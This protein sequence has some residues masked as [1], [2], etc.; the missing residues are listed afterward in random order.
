[1]SKH[2]PKD[3]DA[4]V[5]PTCSDVPEV[6]SASKID[7]AALLP[8][9]TGFFR[10]AGSLTTPPCSEGITWTVLKSPIEASADQIK[11]FAQLFPMNARPLQNPNRRFLLETM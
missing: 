3:Y 6:V 1:M 4:R 7:P 10:Y 5:P 9:D 2:C 11:R 8:V